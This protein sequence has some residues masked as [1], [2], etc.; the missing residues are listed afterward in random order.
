MKRRDFLLL[1]SSLAASPL[2]ARAQPTAKVHHVAYVGFAGRL[3]EMTGTDPVNPATRAFKQGLRDLGY[4]EGQNLLIEWRSA[5][6]NLERLPQIMR[7]LISV[8][9][10]VIV[11]G[12]QPVTQ[13]AHDATRTI[14]IVMTTDGTPV[15]L[16]FVQSLARPGGNITGLTFQVGWDIH[17][18]AF[19][20]LTRE[21]PDALLLAPGSSSYKNRGLIVE[22][23]AQS[24]LPA[25][26][27]AREF[28]DASGLMSYGADLSD[29]HRR[30]A[31]YV[32]KVLKG[33]KPADLPIQQPNKF[34][35]VVNLKTATALGLT[36]PPSLLARAD[37][38]IE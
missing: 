28:V 17:A 21:R 20:L 29:L 16:G 18:K 32:D 23:A 38:V 22:F 3:S 24:R 7:E 25:M 8:D 27:W 19:A 30:A 11:S 12:N 33:A 34:Q 5:E 4:L 13:A 2:V 14:P 9:V 31:G 26:Y 35:L 15:E 37:E 1:G 10:D 36:V 6:G